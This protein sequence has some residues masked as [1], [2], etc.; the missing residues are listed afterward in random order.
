M[1]T[2]A[3]DRNQA[4][5]DTGRVSLR[6]GDAQHLPD[7]LDGFDLI[8]GVNVSMFWTDPAATIT[9]LAARLEPGGRLTLSYMPPPTSD[10]S[11]ET[12]GAELLGHFA[13]AGLIGGETATFDFDPPAVAITGFRCPR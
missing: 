9:Q 12:I 13:Q 3:R 5:V 7:D 11:A 2:T 10:D 8:F 1:T 4:G 6:V